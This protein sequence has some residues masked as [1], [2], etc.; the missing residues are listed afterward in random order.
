MPQLSRIGLSLEE[1]LRAQFD[2]LIAK[3]GYWTCSQ[4]SYAFLDLT[5]KVLLS[6]IVRPNRTVAGTLIIV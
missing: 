3:R 5:R 6:D 1:D 4:A 2:R